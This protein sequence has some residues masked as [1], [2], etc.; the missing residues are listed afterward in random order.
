MNLYENIKRKREEL[1]MTQAELA[2]K[3]GYADK[4]MISKIEK[5]VIDLPQ[6]KIQLFADALNTTPRDLM[7]WTAENKAVTK[8][9]IPVLGRVAAGIP[10]DAIEDVLDWEEI[11]SDLASTGEFFG[12]KFKGHSLDPRI[13]DGDVVSVRKPHIT[14]T[15]RVLKPIENRVGAKLVPELMENVTPQEQYEILEMSKISGFVDRMR[16]T[17]RPTKKERRDL[18]QFVED[19]YDNEFDEF[20]FDEL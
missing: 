14:Y 19:S 15:F 17:G 16:G 3:T 5:G 20:D 11:P 10:I 7:G 18:D 8:T 6:S 4:T 13:A 2:V 1:R 9:K 12:L